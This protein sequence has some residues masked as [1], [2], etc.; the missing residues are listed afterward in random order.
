MNLLIE[1]TPKTAEL[2]VRINGILLDAMAGSRR[3]LYG[4]ALLSAIHDNSSAK[5]PV[6]LAQCGELSPELFEKAVKAF[7][8]RK[9][10]VILEHW[11]S[12]DCENCVRLE[13]HKEPIDIRAEANRLGIKPHEP[14]RGLI[15]Q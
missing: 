4:L 5:C 8:P 14:L 9:G 6:I 13:P 7:K 10:N 1:A 2:V 12:V 3:I 11:A 15:G